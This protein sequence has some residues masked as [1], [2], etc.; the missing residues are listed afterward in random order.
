MDRIAPTLR[1][2][3]RPLGFQRWHRLLF[4]HWEVPESALRPL[5]PR[6]LSL[7]AFEGRLFVGVVAFTMQRVRPLRWMPPVPTAREFHEINLRTYVHL[8]GEEPGIFFFSLDAGSSLAVAAARWGLRMPYHRGAFEHRDDGQRVRWRCDRRWPRPRAGRFEASYEIRAP[9]P[10]SAVGSL[11]FFLA[12]RYQF[13]TEH[14]G[15]PFRA[16]VHHAPYALSEASVEAITPSLLE[17]A[18]MPG[19]GPRTPDYFSP[20]VD[21]EVFAPERVRLSRGS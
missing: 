1:P 7:D 5:V 21:V 18:G 16:R 17:A 15:R 2:D 11:E 6:W 12:E 9:R 10:P 4:S 13:Y 20:S 14:H 8:D 19:D 3:R